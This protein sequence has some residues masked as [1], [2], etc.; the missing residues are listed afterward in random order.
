MPVPSIRIEAYPLR[1]ALKSTIRHAAAARN[2]G[3]SVWVQAQRGGLTGFGE[4]CPRSYV[5]HD[6]LTSS[7]E[8]VK[9]RFGDGQLRFRD[10]GEVI[11]WTD[12]NSCEIDEFPSAWCAVELA[13]L[14]L[15]A[16]ENRCSIE[17]LLGLE[18]GVRGGRYTAVL[19]N[20]KTWKFTHLV[21]HY[22]VRGF[23][24]FKLKLSGDLDQDILRLDILRQSGI[25]HRMTDM[26]IRVDANNLW[27][28]RAPD[29]L[30]YMKEL[31]GRIVAAEEP[32]GPRDIEGLCAL[33][34]A[35]GL[36]VIL[37]ESLCTRNDLE[38]YTG[39]SGKFI[40][41]IKVSRMGGLIRSLN[42]IEKLKSL[43]WP[44]IIGCHVGETSLLTRAAL[45]PG[46]AAG[47]S[48]IGREGAFGDYLLAREPAEPVLKFGRHGILDLQSAYYLKTARGL[49]VIPS[50]NWAMGTGMR[51]RM[52]KTCDDGS[53]D[54]SIL[55]MPDGYDI[56]YRT[57]GPAEGDDALL[58]LHGG[59]SHSGWQAPLATAVRALSDGVTVVA[60]D[61]RGCG[62]NAN[63]GDLASVHAVIDDVVRQVE[64]LKRSF[65]RV[66]LS[67]WCQG[68]QY[69][70]VAAHQLG[71]S[72]AGL[73]LLT[74]GFFWNERFRSVIQVTE[75]IILK[76]L[77]EFRLNPDPDRPY[78]PIPME[79][80]DFTLS[81]EWL[82]YIENDDLKTTM[83]TMKTVYIMDEIQEM[84]WSAILRN[85]LP[86][87]MIL[88]QQDRIVDNHKILSFLQNRFP[89]SGRNRLVTI[90]SA[91]A[92][93]FEK[94]A[95]IAA[96]ILAFISA[97]RAEEIFVCR[98]E[99]V[100]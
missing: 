52:P 12:A 91:H 94:A 85:R 56:H 69:A 8:W 99:N 75:R 23:S 1:I 72:L 19:G 88:A 87:L 2:R 15:L 100:L 45:V 37:D 25:R 35:T 98:R 65:T 4:G 60:A 90:N 76:L 64:F 74:P 47:N 77:S 26:R 97:R 14:D 34:A 73:I 13:V 18:D 43:D 28:G 3:E 93:Q 81:E 62:L 61:R 24:E 50:D 59:M 58:I 55:P 42:I 95:E 36:A 29:A 22:L 82:D 83:V 31:N 57:W 67:G 20:D 38:Q 80:A 33:T 44:V 40:A 68:A 49:E 39:R 79:P 30:E 71:E 66:H 53:P 92:V 17:K 46:I 51:C 63:R 78:V 89:E 21:D 84:S 54:I 41:N 48:L 11:Q 10:V 27:A 6:D 70:S 16:R 5:T 7:V 9:D 96:E 86:L 32:L